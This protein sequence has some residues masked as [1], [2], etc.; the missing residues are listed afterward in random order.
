MVLWLNAC[1]RGRI[2]GKVETG[3]SR[4]MCDAPLLL[5][6]VLD[7]VIGWRAGGTNGYCELI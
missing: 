6:S 5:F 7:W 4:R 2:D 3:G 1:A